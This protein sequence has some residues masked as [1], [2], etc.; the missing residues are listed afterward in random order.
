MATFWKI[1]TDR[2]T[3]RQRERD[4]RVVVRCHAASS[5]VADVDISADTDCL[6]ASADTALTTAA[7]DLHRVTQCNIE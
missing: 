4:E 5:S 6:Y 7:N 1:P 3:G 2:Q